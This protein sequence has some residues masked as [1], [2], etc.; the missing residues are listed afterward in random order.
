MRDNSRKSV[1]V[2]RFALIDLL[3][4]FAAMMVAIMHWGLELGPERMQGVYELPVIGFLIKNGSLGVDIF[5]LISGYV[6]LETAMRKDSLDFLVARFIRLF[7][8]LF[9]SMTIVAIVSPKIV[10][11]YQFSVAS[12]LHSIFLTYQASNISPLATQL[13]TLIFEIKFYGAVA[14][15]LLIFP[16]T[17]KS[18]KGILL[19]LLAWQVLLGIVSVLNNNLFASYSHYLSLGKSGTLFAFGICLNL[20]SRNLKELSF[21]NVATFGVTI[22]FGFQIFSGSFYGIRSA[23]LIACSSLL[24][25]IARHIEF[26]KKITKVLQLLGL[27]SYLIY[28]LHEHL[29]TF[30]MM[31]FQAHVSDNLFVLILFS[32]LFITLSSLLIAY[33]IEKPIQELMKN[34]SKFF[35]NRNHHLN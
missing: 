7:P 25:F 21:R 20:L 10:G 2:Q 4:Y 22:Y 27:S 17:F 5:F 1:G 14:L 28:L 16:K 29:G 31:L 12:Y 30:F 3:R 23:V 8:G 24:I 11:N 15:V 13:W 18:V 35:L 34:K 33:F 32:T 19:L 6:I 9:I 26:S